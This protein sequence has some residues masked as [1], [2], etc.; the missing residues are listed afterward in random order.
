[1]RSV[2]MLGVFVGM[3]LL[4][5]AGAMLAGQ[6]PLNY[7]TQFPA[8]IAT[9]QP[10]FSWWGLVLVLI[11]P[12]IYLV[13]MIVPRWFG[14]RSTPRL[15][16]STDVRSR[17]PAWGWVGVFLVA[18][19]WIVS[20]AH[21]GRFAP[22]QRMDFFFL[23]LGYILTMDGL[24]YRRKG[25]S[26]ASRSTLRFV[27]LF[28]ASSV[29]WWFFEYVNRFV[30]NWYYA[31]FEG[32]DPWGYVL[33]ASLSFSTVLPAL[34]ETAEWLGLRRWI[35]R[36]YAAGPAWPGVGKWSWF[37]G[38]LGV[39][40][41]FCLGLWPHLFFPFAW[42]GPMLILMPFVHRWMPKRSVL[43]QIA[44][45]DYRQLAVLTLCGPLCGFF[46]EMWNYLSW[47]KWVYQLPFVTFGKIFEMPVLGYFGY[48]PFGWECLL[49]L[50]CWM[51]IAGVERDGL[52]ILPGSLDTVATQ[53]APSVP[54]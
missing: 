20:W 47:P 24:V 12:L 14:F 2:A 18:V 30:Q 45:G 15:A 36:R 22:L 13:V 39:M 3:L 40:G 16:P 4:P 29:L 44:R 28:L 6:H 48:C 35:H 11:L 41:F 26:L 5:L 52:D 9:S 25:H 54:V 1:L 37:L 19:F 17:F 46:W 42:L 50:H 32:H 10:G 51:V 33:S 8:Q 53:R 43:T 23:W 38:A 49:I 27:I 34:M 31:G 21:M 7:Y